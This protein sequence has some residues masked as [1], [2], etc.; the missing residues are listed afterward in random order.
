VGDGQPAAMGRRN[1]AAGDTRKRSSSDLSELS[2]SQGGHAPRS[3]I[4]ARLWRRGGAHAPATRGLNGWSESSPSLAPRSRRRGV[5][6][7]PVSFPEKQWVE[8][9]REA[10]QNGR[11]PSRRYRR[12]IVDNPADELFLVAVG[13]SVARC[14]APAAARSV[15]SATSP[16]GQPKSAEFKRMAPGWMTDGGG[17]WCVKVRASIGDSGPGTRT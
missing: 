16:R 3:Q 12:R 7:P 9:G 2:G 10:G 6:G 14:Q 11:G 13:G 5:L 15:V 4:A 8:K 17:G 1:K